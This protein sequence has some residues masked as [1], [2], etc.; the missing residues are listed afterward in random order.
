MISS[1][2]QLRKL[3]LREVKTLVGRHTARTWWILDSKLASQ[4]PEPT[5]PAWAASRVSMYI[6][7]HQQIA[8]LWAKHARAWLILTILRERQ[9]RIPEGQALLSVRCLKCV[10]R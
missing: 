2:L 4:A 3:R 6:D 5:V 10:E 9:A 8:G 1:V 7:C